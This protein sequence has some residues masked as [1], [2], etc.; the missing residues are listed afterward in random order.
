MKIKAIK[1]IKGHRIFRDF[2][3]PVG[4]PEFATYNVIYGWNG[5]GKSTLSNLMRHLETGRPV[6]EG[7]VTFHFEAGPVRGNQIGPDQPRAMIRV[8]NKAFVDET[9]FRS[10]ANGRLN[11]IYFVAAG[12][13]EKRE[14]VESLLKELD[15]PGGVR[16]RIQQAASKE[17]EAIRARDAFATATASGVK[18]LLRGAGS[19]FNNF[20]R[21]AYVDAAD[22]LAQKGGGAITGSILDDASRESLIIKKDENARA[23][24]IFAVP[25]LPDLEEL[26]IEVASVLK[27]TVVSNALDSLKANS[28]L[29]SWVRQGLPLHQIGGHGQLPAA[30]CHFCDQELRVDR[31]ESLRMHFNDS[32]SKL[33][34]E[35][36][37]LE[38]SIRTA[39]L[40][41]T[42]A[43]HPKQEEF[44]KHFHAKYG[45]ARDAVEGHERQARAFLTGLSKATKEKSE[46]AFDAMDI[47]DYVG[48]LPCPSRVES[49]KAFSSIDALVKQH[50]GEVSRFD[51]IVSEAR[52]KLAAD[53]IAK[54]L[55]K[56]LEKR[57]AVSEQVEI[58]GDLRAVELE[59]KAEIAQLDREIS[60]SALPAE[61]LTK[62]LASYLGRDEITI[63]PAATG[64]GY[65]I[66][67]SG[68]A[69]DN[70][71]EGERTAIAF[72]Y[73]LEAL[74]DRSFDLANGIV[75]IDDPVSSLDTNSLCCAFAYMQK[76]TKGAGQLFVLTH[77]FF[78]FRQVKNWLYHLRGNRKAPKSQSYMVETYFIDGV[79]SSRLSP[80]D[81]VLQAFHSEYHYLFKKV[82]E[83][84]QVAAG[85]PLAEYYGL[86]NIGRR[87]LESFYAFRQPTAEQLR[88]K[89]SASGIVAPATAARILA[90]VHTGSHEEGGG[91]DFDMTLLSE[92]PA[93]MR[94]ILSVINEEDSAHHAAM[95]DACADGEGA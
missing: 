62:H 5:S 22:K 63:K 3:W 85:K 32:Y 60:D 79:R 55:P 27:S 92:A 58:Q 52:E 10:T 86:P 48:N 30:K 64:S 54:S 50:N 47:A 4:L 34:A 31:V 36:S 25:D 26:T 76:R 75:V 87:L 57:A 1:P 89:L 88:D 71:S 33:I 28:A 9:I 37:R 40:A 6:S 23:S 12:G 21:P 8:F 83:G 44:G 43:S 7:D 56:L 13:K 29:E 66:E 19:R 59:R 49:A 67:R 73:F 18:E 35:L 45:Q 14:R 2:Q 95:V 39:L 15:G 42:G 68:V 24:I 61:L 38:Q 70:L 16:E 90:F 81:P 20:E 80:L 78:F 91:D 72:L 84:G 93:V 69:A 51:E 77:N 41:W 74:G 46:R 82:I 94:D 11:P 53:V 65:L 17:T